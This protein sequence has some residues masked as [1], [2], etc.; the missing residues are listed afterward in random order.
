MKYIKETS[1]DDSQDCGYST[2]YS[3]YKDDSLDIPYKYKNRDK[4][5]KKKY[6]QKIIKNI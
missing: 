5:K 6:T 1:S 3:V 2:P 4:L